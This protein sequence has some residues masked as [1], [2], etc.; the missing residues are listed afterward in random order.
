MLTLLLL[1]MACDCGPAEPDSRSLDSQ[2]HDSEPVDEGPCVDPQPIQLIYGAPS[3]YERCADG[4]VNK[5]GETVLAANYS[6]EIRPCEDWVQYKS[7]FTDADCADPPGSHCALGF[8][9]WSYPPWC[10]CTTPCTSDADCGALEA[11]IPPEV[12]DLSLDWP[13]CFPARC[14]SGESCPSGECA[15]VTENDCGWGNFELRCRK[16]ADECRSANE[17][18]YDC[19][20][21]DTHLE[22]VG[23][24]CT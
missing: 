11:C 18:D 3:G 6:G 15:L 24:A 22:C 17:C 16:D 2:P 20:A 1:L 13:L 8:S 10:E 21:Y 14:R 5:V 12:H 4:S 7:C 19:W 23:P 9:P